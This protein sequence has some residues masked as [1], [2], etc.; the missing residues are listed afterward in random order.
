VTEDGSSNVPPQ[1]SLPGN[2]DT[3]DVAPTAGE[4]LA[5][6]VD[7]SP[8][9]QEHA[10]PMLDVHAPHAS[11]HTWKDFFIHLAT[12]VI[13]LLIA[14]GLEQLVERV[15]DYYK[16]RE[17]REAL[18][19]EREANGRSLLTNAHNWRWEMAELQNN[20]MVLEYIQHHPGESQTSLPGDL[21]WV[22]LPNF[23]SHAVWDAA[24]QNGVIRL[25][26]LDEANSDQELY[27]Y[28]Q[29]LT[30][31]GNAAWNAI[32]DARRFAFV[33]PDPTHLSPQ[34]LGETIQLTEIAIEKHM[35]VAFSFALIVSG[36]PDL[37]TSLTYHEALTYLHSPYQE[38][39]QGM[40]AAHQRTM[41]RLKAAGYAPQDDEI[42]FHKERQ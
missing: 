8:I 33:D 11:V 35:Q 26:P 42:V 4:A 6:P 9:S 13:G 36:F 31:Q 20:L 12:I 15:H 29:T 41:E 39:P 25:L 32:N 24:Q 17:T 21:R 30:D 7:A 23:S 10:I 16:V 40:A 19:L 5:G 37:S 38:N 14:V 28:L 3:S 27:Q 2:S 22:Q 18:R 1:V 34:Q